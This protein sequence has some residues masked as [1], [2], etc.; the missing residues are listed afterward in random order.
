M[1]GEAPPLVEAT[2]REARRLTG[3]EALHA[4]LDAWYRGQQPALRRQQLETDAWPA[5]ALLHRPL[6]PARAPRLCAA[7]DALAATLSAH[8]LSPQHHLGAPDAAALLAA[9]PTLAALYAPSCFGP[10]VPMLGA[11]LTEQTRLAQALAAGADPDALIDLQLAPTL[12]HELCHGPAGATQGPPAPWMVVEAAAALLGWRADPRHLLPQ[13]PDEA[14][15][16]AA[17]F[18]LLGQELADRFGEGPLLAL[19]SSPRP[20]AAWEAL[21][22]PVAARALAL[23]EWQDW[24][25]RG[26]PPLYP[27]GLRVPA[28]SKL[29]DAASAPSPLTPLLAQAADAWERGAPLPALPI[30]LDAA[31][32]TPWAALPAWSRAPSDR[33]GRRVD[34]ALAA[35]M[36]VHRWD[37]AFTTAPADP[38]DGLVHL[39]VSTARLHVARRPDGVWNEPAAAPFPPPLARRLADRG[40]TQVTLTGV[41]RLDVPR[42]AAILRGLCDA[43]AAPRPGVLTLPA[44]GGPP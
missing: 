42:A 28:W 2:L 3:D 43:D 13:V 36:Q 23:A 19:L 22:G 29:L 32:A 9:R 8:G 6:T 38:P 25:T 1:P 40:V 20:F 14:L 21:A 27:D 17:P 16:A 41:S 15:P 33:H 11:G 18:L 4:R 34:S 35:L 39:D 37:G 31:A 30:L 26:E 44:S 12:V 5:A 7:L 10:G 24:L